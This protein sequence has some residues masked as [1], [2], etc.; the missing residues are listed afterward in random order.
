MLDC[1]I[2][3]FDKKINKELQ[4]QK[5]SEA[6]IK[7]GII[8]SLPPESL[9]FGEF[10]AR[11]RLDNLLEWKASNPDLYPFYWIDPIEKD[12]LDQVKLAQEYGVS[13]FK[14]ICNRFYPDDECAMKVFKA[15]AHINKPILFHSG[16]LWDGADSGKY[17]RPAG[18]EA[19]LKVDGLKFAL[20]HASWP[21]IDECIAVYGKFQNAYSRRPNLSVEMFIDITPGTP[22]IY[23]EELLTK[24]FRVGYDIENNII[25]G[26]DCSLENYNSEWT[27]EWVKR[28]TEIYGKLS[29]DPIII[30]K[31]F[32][33][34]L[35]RFLGLE[36]QKIKKNILR[37]AE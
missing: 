37:P 27:N 2:H 9:G 17:N 18:F 8:I 25:F 15:I 20:A 14:I 7:G 19:L 11:E 35:K 10:E 30:N 26:S 21:W 22:V 13:G 34:N 12:A 32:S 33:G 23:R 5:F 6:G 31:V 36:V 3:I 24:L 29:I 1:H 4:Q 28:D 16:I